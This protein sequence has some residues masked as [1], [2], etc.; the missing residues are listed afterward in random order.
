MNNNEFEIR[1]FCFVLAKDIK[2]I[3]IPLR[4]DKRFIRL[5][6]E[7]SGYFDKIV[8]KVFYFQ[9]QFWK[10]VLKEYLILK[11]KCN[12]KLALIDFNHLRIEWRMNDSFSKFKKTLNL[13]IISFL[14]IDFLYYSYKSKNGYS[15]QLKL[16]EFY[17][18]C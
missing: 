9:K 3:I 14:K 13:L 10:L 1:F 18:Y 7:K 6:V 11:F 4:F 5:N 12:L 17:K 16:I 8:A 2:G 15:I